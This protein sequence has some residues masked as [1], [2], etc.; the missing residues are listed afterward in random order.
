MI[1]EL[2][3]NEAK[4]VKMLLLEEVENINQLIE[5][6]NNNDAAELKE[7]TNIMNDVINKL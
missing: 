6:V 2:T 1:I 3:E 5:E 7:Q 4:L